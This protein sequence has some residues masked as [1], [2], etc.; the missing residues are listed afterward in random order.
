M[1]KYEDK[2][3]RQIKKYDTKMEELLKKK[4]KK[5]E[6]HKQIDDTQI[7]EIN[8]HVDSKPA[9]KIRG[10]NIL[11]LIITFVFAV[12]GVFLLYT[13]VVNVIKQTKYEE[14]EATIISVRTYWKTDKEDGSVTLMAVPTYEYYV[15]GIR[16]EIESEVSTSANIAPAVG[17]KVTIKYNPEKPSEI[18]SASWI[19]IMFFV[20]GIAFFAMG[21]IVFVR[22][23]LGKIQWV[24]DEGRRRR[25]I[26]FGSY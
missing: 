16:Y 1:K 17:D 7:E 26:K 2:Y 22:T 20:M 6:V 9:K 12:A 13:G 18:M 24:H 21:T 8:Q 11:V 14:V 5:E 10:A 23:L 3:E 25:K 15:D 4:K 19:V